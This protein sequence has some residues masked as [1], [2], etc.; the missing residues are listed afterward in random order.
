MVDHSL[1]LSLSHAFNRLVQLCSLARHRR[2]KISSGMNLSLN[3]APNPSLSLSL[4]LSIYL[5]THTYHT[6]KLWFD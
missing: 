1:S 5:S 6:R 3:L 4:Y 2:L